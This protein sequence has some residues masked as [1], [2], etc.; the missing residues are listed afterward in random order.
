MAD[1]KSTKQ[2]VGNT[3]ENIFSFLSDF[4]N[5]KNLM[6]EQVK[7]W[8]STE[9]TCSFTI[10]NLPAISMKIHE[11]LPFTKIV[12]TSHSETPIK[13]ELIYFLKNKSASQTETQLIFKADLNPM[14]S[15]M[16]AKPLQNFVDILNQKLKEFFEKK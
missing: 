11:K 13:F 7:D 6:P 2:T 5:F 14:L 4:N 16:V 8:Q 1:I 9:D 3:A 15:M 10:Q 12:Y